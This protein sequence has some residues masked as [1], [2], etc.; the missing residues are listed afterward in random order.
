MAKKCIPGVICFENVTIV[1]IIVILLLVGFYI[2]KSNKH[3]Q[4]YNNNI[5]IDTPMTMIPRPPFNNGGFVF[6]NSVL[7]PPQRMLNDTLLDPY[8]PPL[9]DN[10]GFNYFFGGGM[11]PNMMPIN[12]PTQGP[13]IVMRDDYQQV[14]ILTRA[15][16]SEMILPLMG[17]SLYTNRDKWNYY[18]MSDKNNIV[19]LPISSRGKNCMSEYGCD[20]LNSGDHVHVDGYNDKFK[21][22]IYDNKLMRYLPM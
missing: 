17:Q 20:S 15:N 13:P 12:I 3:P 5:A 16:G 11:M 2:Y 10:S 1:I 8:Q 4:T 18:T 6:N 21:V 14:G 7:S 22:T 9:R 19:K